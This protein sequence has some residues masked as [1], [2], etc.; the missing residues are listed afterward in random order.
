ML[1]L[2]GCGDCDLPYSWLLH[3]S[4]E[5]ERERDLAAPLFI[6]DGSVLSKIHILEF[7][8]IEAVLFIFLR[9]KMLLILLLGKSF[10]VEKTAAYVGW[11]CKNLGSKIEIKTQK[12]T[13]LT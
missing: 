4:R 2:V 12:K 8:S 6:M 7:K 3:T 13:N 1:V 10:A 9:E 5:K 11:S